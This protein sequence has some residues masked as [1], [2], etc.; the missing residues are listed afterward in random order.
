VS[1]ESAV[2]TVTLKGAGGFDAPWVVVRAETPQDLLQRLNALG[3]LG[4]LARVTEVARELHGV[5][6]AD[7]GLRPSATVV[8]PDPVQPQPPIPQAFV[9]QPVTSNGWGN[10]PVPPGY[11]AP[12]PQGGY[13]PVQPQQAQAGQPFTKEDRYGNTFVYNDPAAPMCQRGAMVLATRTSKA[14][15]PYTMWL[16][17]AHKACPLWREQGNPPVDPSQLAED[18][19]PS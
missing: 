13:Q 18:Q 12:P 11:Q 14:K 19:W 2:L 8:V 16:D 9:A 7:Q 15:K 3:S 10:T 6:A 5:Y 1:D 17:P 4:I